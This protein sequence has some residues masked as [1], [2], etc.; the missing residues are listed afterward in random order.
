MRIFR[1][2]G[3]GNRDERVD[4]AIARSVAEAYVVVLASEIVEGG[5]G[6]INPD[7]VAFH[8]CGEQGFPSGRTDKSA[9]VGHSFRYISG[10][11]GSDV[12]I[13]QGQLS[14]RKV[15]LGDSHFSHCAVVGGAGVVEVELGGGIRAKR[16]SM[17]SRS[18]FAFLSCA[19]ALLSTAR[20]RLTCAL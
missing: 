3:K 18:R 15:G 17:R 14:L 16:G 19:R 12:G 10:Y 6:E 2:V 4:F 7:R 9:D 5:H 8:D 13:A 20:A 11:R 1:T